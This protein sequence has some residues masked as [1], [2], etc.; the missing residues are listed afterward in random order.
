M[1]PGRKP[2]E[3]QVLKWVGTF[4]QFGFDLMTYSWSCAILGHQDRRI[5]SHGPSGDRQAVQTF[6]RRVQASRRPRGPYRLRR[7]VHRASF[8]CPVRRQS[9][10]SGSSGPPS[11]STWTPQ[12]TCK[13][14]TPI[15]LP[16]RTPRLRRLIRIRNK[17]NF[18][19][20][21][22]TFCLFFLQIQDRLIVQL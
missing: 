15:R 8:P 6:G 12:C 19:K 10:S 1:V 9:C 5:R 18:Q 2:L 3:G 20:L 7:Q 14:R 17:K 16:P 11:C 13:F 22:V 4:R 21:V